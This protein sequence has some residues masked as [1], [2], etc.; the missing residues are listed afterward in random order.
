MSQFWFETGVAIVWVL[1]LLLGIATGILAFAALR[2]ILVE[3]DCG[4]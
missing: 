1:S 3:D 4:K 2:Y